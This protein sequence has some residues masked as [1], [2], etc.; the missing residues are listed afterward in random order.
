MLEKTLGVP[1]FQEQAMRLAIDVAG[2]SPGEADL[3]RKAMGTWR[4]QGSVAS[5]RERFVAGVRA[6][7]VAP[8]K[9]DELFER[10]TGFGEYGFPE[11]HAASFALLV[12]A[13]A[14]LK[15]HHPAA[16]AAGLLN[17]QPMGFYQP[18]QLVRDAREHGVPVL[19]VCVQASGW[20]SRLAAP[21]AEPV[22]ARGAPPS[23]EREEV[24][25]GDVGMARATGA[26]VRPPPPPS[27]AAAGEGE[28]GTRPDQPTKSTWTGR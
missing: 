6:R 20:D 2:F 17:S 18:A 3:L 7:G 27:P 19:P 12:Y 14:W 23:A 5:F 11:S 21:V 1:I 10:L 28:R 13:S 22:P 26:A 25:R 15:R 8:A 16:F 4:A 9:A 24:G